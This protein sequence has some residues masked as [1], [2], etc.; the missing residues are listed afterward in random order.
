[1]NSSNVTLNVYK[2]W[3]RTADT[4]PEEKWNIIL[5]NERQFFREYLFKLQI[6]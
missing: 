3:V 5:K 4:T 2:E 1:M 6:A